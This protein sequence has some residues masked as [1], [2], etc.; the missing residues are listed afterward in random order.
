[1][2]LGYKQYLKDTKL[3]P[4]DGYFCTFE[5]GEIIDPFK[6]YCEEVN[7]INKIYNNDDGYFDF[8]KNIIDIGS[9]IGT[10]SFILPFNY[11]YMFEGNK[12]FCIIAE[13][14]MLLHNKENKFTQ[15]ITLLSDKNEL[16]SYDGFETNYT[17]ENNE[18]KIFTNEILSTTLDEYNLDN[19][20]FIKIDV[21]G[22]EYKVLNGGIETI[23]RN[24][25]PPILFELWPIGHNNMSKE[26]HQQL[27]D[28][29]ENLGYKI[30][31][32]W[33]QFD[34]HLAIHKNN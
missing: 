13:F 8:S 24:N 7:I 17:Y 26:R 28:F 23:K 16:I 32:K 9:C 5:Y 31:W 12:K 30:L 21:E 22:M 19:I 3:I 34:T 20:G 27:V 18:N 33:G 2:Q 6:I 25:Y 11:S 4:N 14:N 29:L 1:M 10:Y 15:Y